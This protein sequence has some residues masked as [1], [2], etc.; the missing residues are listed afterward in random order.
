MTSNPKR[1]KSETSGRGR[2]EWARAIV[3]IV[4][5][6]IMVLAAAVVLLYNR[7]V[8]RPELPPQEDPP[9]VE[10]S[11][12]VESAHHAPSVEPFFQ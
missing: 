9:A 10:S 2:K 8:K 5:A 4:L 11:E 12:P 7:W 6:V 1:K 3:L